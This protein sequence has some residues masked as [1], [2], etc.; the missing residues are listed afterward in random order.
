[1]YKIAYNL[2][3]HMQYVIYIVICKLYE[4]IYVFENDINMTIHV[5]LMIYI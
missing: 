3:V 4:K 1:M 5:R 2:E